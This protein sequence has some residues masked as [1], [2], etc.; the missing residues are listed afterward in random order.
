LTASPT[1]ETLNLFLYLTVIVVGA[2][3]VVFLTG[4]RWLTPVALLGVVLWSAPFLS[5]YVAPAGQDIALL[6]TFGFVALFFVTNVASVVRRPD[7]H[8]LPVQIFT[9]LLTVVYLIVWIF[10]AVSDNWHSLLYSA[11]ALVFAVGAFLV[12]AHTRNRQVF[13]IYGG[14]AVGLIGAATA[15]ELDGILLTIAFTLEIALFTIVAAVL[16]APNDIVRNISLL[17][18]IPILMSLPSLDG[19]AWRDSVLH[20]D[21]FVLL[22]M[23][24]VT[25][26]VGAFLLGR[27]HS[28]DNESL[29]VIGAGFYFVSGFYATALVWLVSHALLPYDLGTTVSLV[30]YTIVGLTL[31]IQGPKLGSFLLRNI[32]IVFIGGVVARL[33]LVDIWEMP[34]AGRIVTF[35]VIGVMLISTA[36]IGKRNRASAQD[37][38]DNE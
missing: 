35:F 15:A 16:R 28:D 19:Y 24:L 14:A 11:W 13:Y 10:E 12:Y 6:F 34:I 32:G 29:G 21:A 27:A 5:Y 37:S 26:R 36:F 38:Y 33:L 8:H 25:L 30:V 3:W 2:L 22:M 20:G 23:M 4:W 9:A 31:F 17:F 7:K 1:P 18:V